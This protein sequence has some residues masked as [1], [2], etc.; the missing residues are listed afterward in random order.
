MFGKFKKEH[1]SAAHATDRPPRH[2]R[3][4]IEIRSYLQREDALRVL[5]FGATSPVN[6][7]YLTTLGHSVYMANVVED[8]TRPEWL[9]PR[10]LFDAEDAKPELDIDRFISSNLDFSGRDFDVI[11]LWDTANFLP[12]EMVP[13]L[14][15]RLRKVLRP[16]GK[17]LAFFH[18][19]LAGPETVFSRFQLGDGDSLLALDSGN[20][21]VRQVYQTRQVEKL[22]EGYSSVRFFLGK[23][24]VREVI[25]TR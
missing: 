20:F 2:S 10:N 5:D 7:N 13:A 19:R 12:P 8:A 22:L 23:D 24:N 4:W 21:P 9:R 14:F 11:L 1:G 17:L 6:I 18:A 25:A 16:D 15:S 3:G